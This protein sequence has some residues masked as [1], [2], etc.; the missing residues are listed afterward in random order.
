MIAVNLVFSL[1]GFLILIVLYHC[2]SGCEL[3]PHFVPDS[4][5]WWPWWSPDF[6]CLERSAAFWVVVVVFKEFRNWNKEIKLCFFHHVHKGG[7][8]FLNLRKHNRPL[9]IVPWT[10]TETATLTLM[11][12]RLT[13]TL[14]GAVGREA[15]GTSWGCE[16]APSCWPGSPRRG[17]WTGPGW[18]SSVSSSRSPKGRRS[19][20][21]CSPPGWIAACVRPASGGSEEGSR[22]QQ[23]GL[24]PVKRYNWMQRAKEVIKASMDRCLHKEDT[25][26]SEDFIISTVG[27]LF[28]PYGILT[29]NCRVN[30]LMNS[31]LFCSPAHLHF[32]WLQARCFLMCFIRM[33]LKKEKKLVALCEQWICNN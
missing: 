13:S 28:P 23:V 10:Q 1:I 5:I 33:W 30:I 9:V 27:V 16:N 31:P 19:D 6:F 4:C 17:R 7:Y 14:V 22:K 15:V 11:R 18:C 25:P 20:W 26:N 3:L 29:G 21:W 32:E 24:I 2:L 8:V 12:L